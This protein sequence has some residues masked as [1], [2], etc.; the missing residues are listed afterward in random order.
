MIKGNMFFKL[1]RQNE[2]IKD[3]TNREIKNFFEQQE[4]YY[5]PVIVENFYS[6]NYIKIEGDGDRDGTL[7]IR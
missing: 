2:G 1:I 5:R 3:R 7:S 6:N 4:D